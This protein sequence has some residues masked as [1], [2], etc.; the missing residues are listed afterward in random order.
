MKNKVW[1]GIVVVLIAIVVFWGIHNQNRESDNQ[2]TIKVGVVAFLSG[3]LGQVGNDYLD[4]IKLA[5]KKVNTIHEGLEIELFIEDAKNSSKEAVASFKKIQ[6]HDVSAF[7]MCGDNQ[8][9]PTVPLAITAKIPVLASILGS[10]KSL[11]LNHTGD[12]WLFINWIS[13]KLISES[14]ADYSASEL[15]LKQIALLTVESEYGEEARNVFSERFK[16]NGG[17]I[18]NSETFAQDATTLRLQISK[19]LAHKPQ[20]IYVVG[21][22]GAYIAAINQIKETGFDGVILTET[23][24]INPESKQGIS[25]FNNIIYADTEFEFAQSVPYGKAFFDSY[26]EEYGKE[27]SLFS[28]FGYDSVMLLVNAVQT[29]GTSKRDIRDGLLKIQNEQTLNGSVSFQSNG[30]VTFLPILKKLDKNGNFT[31][32]S[33]NYER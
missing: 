24:I 2:N 23:S 27:P 15:G 26:V 19:I 31:V 13:I 11:E 7:L 1:I 20:A 3:Q 32:I 22:G 16:K 25:D 30:E 5:Q 4:G 29:S 21:F 18:S 33:K 14:L 17:S 8:V 28:A 12:T 10:T 6:M 9:P